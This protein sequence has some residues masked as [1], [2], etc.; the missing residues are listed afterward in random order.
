ML[1][2]ILALG[3]VVAIHEFGHFIIAKMFGVSCPAFSVG[4]GTRLFGFKWKETD[5]RLSLLPLGGYVKM[6]GLTD[7]DTPEN[8]NDSDSFLSK[9]RWQR[10]LI[11]LAGPFINFA[12]AFVGAVL[13]LSFYGTP[14]ATNRIADVRVVNPN[15]VSSPIQPGDIIASVNERVVGNGNELIDALTAAANKPKNIIII[16]DTEK[17]TV[18]LEPGKNIEFMLATDTVKIDFPKAIK[19]SGSMIWFMIERQIAGLKKIINGDPETIKQVSGPI[20]IV[21][22][23][24]AM[25]QQFGLL[26]GVAMFAFILSVL[27][28]FMNLLPIPVLDGGNM[29]ILSVEMVMRRDINQKF[30]TSIMVL[31][32]ILLVSLMIFSTFNDLTR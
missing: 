29:L 8:I 10:F 6:K 14:Q 23:G 1:A 15:I 4:I 21:K 5:F 27:L 24:S 18:A 11:Y 16:R 3:L 25:S 17:R 31:G 32:L 19:E 7:L 28:G 22:A 13:V 20:G 2:A 26:E 30:K 12:T 9:P